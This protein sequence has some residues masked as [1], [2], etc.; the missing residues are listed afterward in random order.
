MKNGPPFPRLLASIWLIL[1]LLVNILAPFLSA[2]DP[3]Q[4]VGRPLQSASSALP[5]GTD[6]LGRDFASRLF[7]GGRQTLAAALLAASLAVLLGGLVGL[8]TVLSPSW[9]D[10]VLV[11]LTNATLAI[12][13]LLLAM[14]LV[15]GL[16][17]GIETVILAVGIGGA[18]GF[19]RLSRTIFQQVRQQGY[20]TAA[21]ALGGSRW[22]ITAAHLL[23]N[24]GR[25]LI[26]LATTH[27]AWALLGTTTLSFLGLAGDPSR[28]DWGI[29]LNQGRRFLVSAPHL[30]LLPGLLI[31]LTILAVHSV[32]D[33]LGDDNPDRS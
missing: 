13:G 24:A 20:V 32:G 28:P 31:S 14:L 22:W 16:G 3:I 30:A 5:L 6:N 29:M 9:V 21:I 10:R 25:Q 17:P 1:V 2:N 27:F 4:P 7:Y 19:M 33:W 11:W 18:P 23:P 12:P 15:A 8:A 26:S